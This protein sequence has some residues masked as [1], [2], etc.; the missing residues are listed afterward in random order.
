MRAPLIGTV[1]PIT[2]E[3]PNTRDKNARDVRCVSEVGNLV[4]FSNMII[5]Y[6]RSNEL[7]K[8]SCYLSN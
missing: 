8:V 6:E 7:R 4:W 3:G 2:Q 5:P 1:L